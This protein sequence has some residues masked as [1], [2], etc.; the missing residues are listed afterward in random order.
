MANILVIEDDPT[1]LGLLTMILEEANHEVFGA[2]NAL[3]ALRRAESNVLDLVV[4]DI[5][6]EGDTDGLTTLEQIKSRYPEVRTLVMTG[7]AIDDAPLRAVR[8]KVDDYL[9]KP[10]GEDD[11]LAS[12]ERL[13]QANRRRQKFDGL[14]T[15]LRSMSRSLSHRISEA[16]EATRKSS[17]VQDLEKVRDGFY[18]AYFTLIRSRKLAVRAALNVWDSLE[19]VERGYLRFQADPAGYQPEQLRSGSQAY[20]QLTE[21]LTRMAREDQPGTMKN[22]FPFPKFKAFYDALQGSEVALEELRLAYALWFE[23][24]EAVSGESRE[25]YVRLWGEVNTKPGAP[26]IPKYR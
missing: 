12:V 16:W 15:T 23:G 24:P 3:Q 26:I 9:P 18:Q 20:A 11:F 21:K 2:A 1:L 17:A 13:L 22:T 8:I 5:R 6:I 4:S 19:A 7:F 25:L 14:L 10:F